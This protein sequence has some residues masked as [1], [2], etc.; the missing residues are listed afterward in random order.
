MILNRIFAKTLLCIVKRG[1]PNFDWIGIF[2]GR[3]EFDFVSSHE[4]CSQ[5]GYSNRYSNILTTCQRNG[6]MSPLFGHLAFARFRPKAGIG[7]KKFPERKLGRNPFRRRVQG[8]KL[9]TA[10]DFQFPGEETWTV[11]QICDAFGRFLN[12]F[13]G[14]FFMRKSA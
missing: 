13:S 5:S 8:Q 7:I 9:S 14:N 4:L 2:V 11:D 3:G 6:D 10:P 12:S 1:I